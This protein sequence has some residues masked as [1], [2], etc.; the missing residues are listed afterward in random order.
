[1]SDKHI[2]EVIIRGGPALRGQQQMISA[3]Y[4]E[5]VV[6]DDPLDSDGP[7]VVR[8]GAAKPI[9]SE[10]RLDSILGQV[11]AQT[12]EANA[13]L[14]ATLSERDAEIAALRMQLSGAQPAEPQQA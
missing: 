1:M 7:Q 9:L 13:T 6:Q 5:A 4:I 8:Y 3:H 14:Q 10:P 12:L 11:Q 2:Y